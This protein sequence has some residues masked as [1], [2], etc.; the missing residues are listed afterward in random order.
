MAQA[1]EALGR[2]S[3]LGFISA[4]VV[5]GRAG[6]CATVDSHGPQVAN[7]PRT[8]GLR[9]GGHLGG[10]RKDGKKKSPKRCSVCVKAGRD[11]SECLS[12]K[13]RGN[14]ALCPYRR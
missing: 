7:G 5:A 2:R 4:H 9:T 8:R 14:R 13:G 1:V 10:R 12:C 6:S 3:Q 11:L